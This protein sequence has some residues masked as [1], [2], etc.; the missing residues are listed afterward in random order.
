MNR[1]WMA[2]TIALGL[3]GTTYGVSAQD[4]KE[5]K[6]Q[7]EV[8]VQQNGPDGAP[9]IE[10][11]GDNMVFFATEMSFGGK[12]VKGAP[13]SAQAV[14]E[15]TQALADGN[16]IVHKN[17]AQVYRDSEGRTRREQAVGAVGPYAVQGDA[18]QTLFI[19]DPVSGVSYILDPRSKTARK[20]PRMELR[21]RTEDRP[22]Q[23]G[24]DVAPKPNASKE[25]EMVIK[26]REAQSHTFVFNAPA[27]PPGSPDVLPPG[28]GMR[29]EFFGSAS[30]AETK[31]EKLEVRQIEGVQAEGVRYTTTIPAG[32]IGNEQ[33]IQ[34]VNERWYSPELQVI[35]MTRHSDPRFGETT[36][37]L[38]NIQRGEPNPS[39]F[40]VP[41]DYTV[42]EPP[43]GPVRTMRR[44]KMPAAPPPQLQEN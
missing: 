11:G 14:T 16:H 19:N 27:P 33:A 7:V 10:M 25:R 31:T 42:K 15:S 29:V 34:I 20:M 41:A 24:S 5:R 2:F 43:A 28:E 22:T 44:S 8:F 4:T 6:A 35:V 32:D 21:W 30:K 3:L 18:P 1:K 23:T 9:K 17:T 38:T 13:Y 40:Q 12:V 39:L 26:E 36:Y 37:R